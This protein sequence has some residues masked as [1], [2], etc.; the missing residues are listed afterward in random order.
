MAAK[1]ESIYE[2]VPQGRRKNEIGKPCPLIGL[3]PCPLDENKCVAFRG[4][5]CLQFLMDAEFL[6]VDTRGLEVKQ[7]K[8][9]KGKR[10]RSNN[11]H[12]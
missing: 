9:A 12:K 1:E 11:R 5:R 4:N 10:G 2:D 7:K 6:R 8:G 3:Q